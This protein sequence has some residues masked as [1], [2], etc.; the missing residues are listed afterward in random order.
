[1]PSWR[2]ANQIS[3]G[4]RDYLR[5]PQHENHRHSVVH[6]SPAVPSQL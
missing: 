2:N 1:M 3:P 4:S 5:N 6:L